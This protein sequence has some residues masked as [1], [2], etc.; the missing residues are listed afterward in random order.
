MVATFRYT[1]LTQKGNQVQGEITA[2]TR[3]MAFELLRQMGHYPLEVH[4]VTDKKPKQKFGLQKRISYQDL[5]LLSRQ[6]ANLFKGGLPLIRCLEALIEH[7]ENKFLIS[8]LREIVEDV[9]SGS[10]FHEA[11]SKHGDFFPPLYVALIKAGESAGR[12]HL[13]L[14]WLADYMERQQERLSQVKASLAYPT[15]LVCFGSIAVFLLITFMV[16]RF[17]AIYAEFGQALPLPTTVL[18]SI[19]RF[20]VKWWWLFIAVAF[21]LFSL[22]KYVGSTENGRLFIDGLKLRLPIYSRLALKMAVVR[23]CRALAT[24]LRGGVPILEAL[25]IA[26]DAIGNE[27]LAREIMRVRRRVREG[28]KIAEHLRSCNLFPPLLIHMLAVGEEIGDLP[29][30]LATVS[31]TLDV[32]IDASLKT[33]VGLVEP[34]IIL[35]IGAIVAFVIFAMVL[36][37][38]QMNLMAGM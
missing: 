37:I 27:V 22:F 14:D 32:E 30:A 3:E 26:K 35:L 28:E 5:T 7:T 15:V 18:M 20:S 17:Q 19:S 25:E 21:S 29:S 13:I 38:F 12:L 4:L 9:R 23:F 36:P 10:A 1:A 33:L 24:L 2:E 16:P 34:A 8:V 11:L 31:D 6:L